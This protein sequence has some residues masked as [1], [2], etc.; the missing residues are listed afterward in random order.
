MSDFTEG[1]QRD[2]SLIYHFHLSQLYFGVLNTYILNH[3]SFRHCFYN[4][5]MSQSLN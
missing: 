5:A 2:M 1:V 3:Y 4:I